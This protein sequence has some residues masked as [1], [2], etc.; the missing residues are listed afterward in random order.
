[1]Y[2]L[3]KDKIKI[4][5]FSDFQITTNKFLLIMKIKKKKNKMKKS[6]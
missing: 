3:T 5:K 1:M 4:S 2:Q 6:Q